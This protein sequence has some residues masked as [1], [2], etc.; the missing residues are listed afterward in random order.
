MSRYWCPAVTSP[1]LDPAS[2]GTVFGMA[3]V[4]V[5][6]KLRD[7]CVVV[8]A[9]GYGLKRLRLHSLEEIQAT[10]QVQHG[11]SGFDPIAADVAKAL[12]FA[13]QQLRNRQREK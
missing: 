9:D 8:A 6:L 3:T 12:K 13:A 1:H 10:Y 2:N 5:D 11:R 4:T 7:C